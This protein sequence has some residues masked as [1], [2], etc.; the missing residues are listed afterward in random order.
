MS[1]HTIQVDYEDMTF[2]V[3]FDYYPACK[4]AREN[5]SGVQ[6]EPDEPETYDLCTVSMVHPED[7]KINPTSSTVTVPAATLLNKPP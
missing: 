2:D 4:G 1:N 3:N 7:K 6:L 5:G